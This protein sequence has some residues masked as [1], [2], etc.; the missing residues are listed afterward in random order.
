MV[1]RHNGLLVCCGQFLCS[2]GESLYE[3]DVVQIDLQ[4]TRNAEFS[5]Q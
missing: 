1:T 2:L 3:E 5:P 4:I